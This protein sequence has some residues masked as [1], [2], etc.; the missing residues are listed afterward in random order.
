MGRLTIIT[1][2]IHNKAHYV[3]SNIT[4]SKNAEIV[5]SV[6]LLLE[7]YLRCCRH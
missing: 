4:F 7:T 6:Y 3:A 2:M 5:F 1:F